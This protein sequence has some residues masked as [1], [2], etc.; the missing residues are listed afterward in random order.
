MDGALGGRAGTDSGTAGDARVQ[1]LTDGAGRVVRT[2]DVAN[3]SELVLAGAARIGSA[4]LDLTPETKNIAG[5]AYVPTRYALS[6]TT[7]FLVSFSFRLYGS[8]G[9]KGDGFAFLWQND[10]RGTSA[11]GAAGGGLGYSGITPSVVVEFD[12]QANSY[13]AGPN[14]ISITTDGQYMTAIGDAPSP[15]PLSDG[16]THYAWI[17]YNG[18]TRTLSVDV[19]STPTRPTTGTVSATVD[20]AATVG[21]SAYIGF[22][23]A[24]GS[25]TEVNAIESFSIG[26]FP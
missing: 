1:P 10:P 14:R 8:S 3:A 18:A 22:T 9:P 15:V 25:A 2:I 4:E 20:L 23:A 16:N 17:E 12:V 5:A 21:S 13:D 6:A 7:S 11:L 19:G 24:C 26:Y